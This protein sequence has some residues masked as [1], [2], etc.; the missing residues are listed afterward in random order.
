MK[1]IAL[2]SGGLDSL[3]AAK[4]IQAQ[5][6]DIIP[7][8]FK[9]PFCPRSF[10][11]G[12]GNL[13][14]ELKYLDIGNDFLKLLENP[15][16][17]FGSQM[18]PCIDCKILMLRR[19]GELMGPWGAKFLV[20]GE[21]LG[22]RPMSQ[23]KQALERIAKKA[24][25]EG[26]VLRPLSAKLIP[27]TIAEK[28]E[29]V[30][31]EKLLNFSGRSRKPQIELAKAFKIKDYAQPAGGCLLTD[32][33]FSKKIKDLIAHRELNVDNV[34]LL[35]IGRHFRISE[36]AKLIVGRNELENTRLVNFAKNNDYLFY[37]GE[38]IAGPTCLGRGSFSEELIRISCGITY[39]YC[40][41]NNQAEAE[42]FYKKVGD[43][44]FSMTV[45]PLGEEE[46]KS[47][48]I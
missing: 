32:P 27:E 9:I 33:E 6:I 12:S 1:A 26:L 10:L 36:N 29:W 42:I 45:L 5:G 41:R 34:E 38:E 31:R 4:L 3:L 16:H 11:P 8:N 14:Q 39:C 7:L 25:L 28:E 47:L 13:G 20:T 22:Q 24:G 35:K 19:A 44:I 21:V 2:I 18:N 15:Q 30:S 40:D 43:E 48:K 17:G 37:P 23:H 46:A